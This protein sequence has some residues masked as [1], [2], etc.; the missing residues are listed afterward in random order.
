VESD[1]KRLLAALAGKEGARR[2]DPVAV[3]TEDAAA[4]GFGAGPSGERLD[5]A[6]WRLIAKGALEVVME[7]GAS[8][9][10]EPGAFYRLTRVGLEELRGA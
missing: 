7:P 1:A 2:G 10:E 8:A 3:G 9:G 5:R 4:A 6:V